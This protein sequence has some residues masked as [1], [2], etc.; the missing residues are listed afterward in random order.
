L[1]TFPARRYHLAMPEQPPNH[2]NE[3]LELAD[4]ARRRADEVAAAKAYAHRIVALFNARAA[5]GRRPAFFPTIKCALVAE[6]PIV[7]TVCPACRTITETDLRT[8]DHHP[9][10]T[11][12]SIIPK[13]SCQRCRPNAPF[14][15]IIEVKAVAGADER[16]PFATW[17]M[18][19]PC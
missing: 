3:R 9:L 14:A 1:A 19:P 12:A 4:V 5:R 7:H 6:T 10:A 15:R 13:V 8:I 2:K 16:S 17:G 11:V 18:M